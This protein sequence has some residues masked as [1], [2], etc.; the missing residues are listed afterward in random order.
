M[1]AVVISSYGSPEVL[2]LQQ[3][4]IPEPNN[5]EVLIKVKAAGINRPDIIQRKGK[6]AA[7]PDAPQDIP[8]LEVSG[9]IHALGK[10]VEGWKEGDEVCALIPGGG[11]AEYAI[12]DSEVCLR[13]PKG[14]TFEEAAGMPE[15]L[16]T[17]WHNIFNLGRLREGEHLL[18]HGGSSGI[19]MTA[20]QLGKA[21]GAEVSV[22][23]S[24]DEKGQFALSLGANRYIKYTKEDFEDVLRDNGVDVVLDM[25]GGDYFQKNVNLLRPDGRLVHINAVNGHK[26][27][28]N[29]WDVMRK[30]LLV[31]GSTLRNR[32]TA[33]KQKLTEQITE[34]VYPIID[35]GL[36]KTKINRT[37]SLED[38]ADAHALMESSRHMGKIILSIT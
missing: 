12:A 7:P 18:V 27:E 4:S 1:K 3:R 11:Y 28:L 15:T 37:F 22:T 33:F 32:S 10:D 29:L 6:Y 24:T 17:V 30:R 38:A 31:T 5:K 26:V 2:Q 8:G 9:V 19:G 34:H 13:K 35:K 16:Y 25:V 20:I 21:F 23:V 36:Y 14:F